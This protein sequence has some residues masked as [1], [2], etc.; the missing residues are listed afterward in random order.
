VVWRGELVF[1]LP[2]PKAP[3]LNRKFLLT[4]PALA[5]ADSGRQLERRVVRWPAGQQARSSKSKRMSDRP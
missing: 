1:N 3:P 4:A 2:S 5:I